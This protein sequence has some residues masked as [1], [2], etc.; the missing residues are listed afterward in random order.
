MVTRH[1]VAFCT[2]EDVIGQLS[3]PD[4]PDVNY[5]TARQTLIDNQEA[6]TNA[7]ITRQIYD[8]SAEI[9]QYCNR[10]FVPYKAG[11]DHRL[12]V[13]SHSAC[14]QL[15]FSDDLLSLTD[16]KCDTTA[17]D[18]AEYDLHPLDAPY[19][20][21]NVYTVPSCT[22]SI[23]RQNVTVTGVWGYHEDYA[24]AWQD[25]GLTLGSGLTASATSITI[26]TATFSHL[27][28]IQIGSEWMHVTNIDASAITVERGVLGS[29]AATHDSGDSVYRYRIMDNV[30]NTAINAVIYAFNTKQRVYPVVT[31]NGDTVIGSVQVNNPADRLPVRMSIGAV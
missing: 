6:N 20:W 4:S 18:S 22:K 24:N 1:R 16:V 29:T 13:A 11:L 26:D 17:F 8:K 5:V 23:S 12:Q 21:L 25:T 14:Y 27:E 9:A 15:L 7:L 30:R 28:Y 3:A 10:T 19:A 31:N 2:L